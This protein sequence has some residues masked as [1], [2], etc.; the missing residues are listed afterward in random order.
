M[1]NRVAIKG[2]TAV[3]CLLLVVLLFHGH[4]LQQK[5]KEN[6][7]RLTQLQE[8]YEQEQER[9]KEIEELQ[10]YMQSEEYMEKYAKEKIG[11]LK[12]N[13]ILFKENK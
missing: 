3:V 6:E 9:T 4:S 11:L 13:E 1:S 10:E 12:E 8:A 7:V 5:V 2:I